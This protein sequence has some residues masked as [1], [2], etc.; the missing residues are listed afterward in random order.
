MSRLKK[1]VALKYKFD[2]SEG[3]NDTIK[4][5][6]NMAMQLDNPNN[7]QVLNILC[8]LTKSSVYNGKQYDSLDPDTAESVID[9]LINCISRCNDETEITEVY[10][11]VEQFIPGRF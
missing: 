1:V 9:T 6:E 4:G 11:D 7:F 8:K 2:V 5:L 10:A 3:R